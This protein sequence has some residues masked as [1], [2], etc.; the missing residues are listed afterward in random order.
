MQDPGNGGSGTGFP[1]KNCDGYASPL[2]ADIHLP[3]CY[4]P[5]KGVQNYKENMDYPTNGKCPSGWKHVPHMFYEVYWNTPKFQDRW[6][7]GQGK[8]PFVLA[9]GDPTGYSLHADFINGWNQRLFNRSST[10]VMLVAPV[11]TNALA[12]SVD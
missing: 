1:D 2:R 4:N 5:A 11:W 7:P 3:S 12:S 10:T 6:T 8:Q 9:N